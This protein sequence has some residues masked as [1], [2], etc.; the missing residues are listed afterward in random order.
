MR[1]MTI[2]NS[3]HY[4]VTFPMTKRVMVNDDVDPLFTYLKQAAG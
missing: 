2:V 4:G 3:R 1:P